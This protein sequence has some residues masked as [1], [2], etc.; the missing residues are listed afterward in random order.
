MIIN[1]L[2]KLFGGNVFSKGNNKAALNITNQEFKKI[3][4]QVAKKYGLEKG[5]GGWYS[6]SKETL[7][8]LNLQKSNYSN[9]YYLNIKT[10]IHGIYNQEYEPNKY[11]IV[12]HPGIISTR[13]PNEYS[14]IFDLESTLS[15]IER[16][17]KLDIFFKDFLIPYISDSKSVK[18]ILK[19]EK[20]LN[21]Y[22]FPELKLELDQL[23]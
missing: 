5:D 12:N 19:L 13:Q 10:Y 14:Y 20:E 23:S 3:F 17:N 4:T 7:V 11:W 15:I 22:L 6:E 21:I 18:G 8:T 1:S 2:R 16:E 9:L